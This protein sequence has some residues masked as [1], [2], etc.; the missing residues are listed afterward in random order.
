MSAAT[1]RVLVA[2]IGNVFLGDDGFGVEV[3]RRLRYV[4]LPERVDVVDYG[5]RGL[6]LAYDLLDGR[7]GLLILVDALPRDPMG[8]VLK[9]HLRDQRWAGRRTAVV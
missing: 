2:G 3:V 1:P 7:H 8:K 6:H 9:R 4:P 5:I